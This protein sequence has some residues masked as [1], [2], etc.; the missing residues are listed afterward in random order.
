MGIRGAA[1][2]LGL[3]GL[4][5]SCHPDRNIETPPIHESG[6]TGSIAGAIFT[7]TPDGTVVNENVGYAQKIEVYLD[8][9]PGPNAPQKAA[10]LPD[11]AYYFQV[12]D[13]SG[14]VLLS[15]D[16]SMCRKVRVANG[17]I[18]ELLNANLSYTVGKK[19]IACHVQDSPDGVAGPSGRHDLNTDA[20]HGGN[21]AIVV[22]LMPFLDTPNN[23][24]VY[25]AWM[26][27]EAQYQDNGG[28]PDAIPQALT[29]KVKGFVPDPGF[30]GAAVPGSRSQVKTDNFKVKNPGKPCYSPLLTVKKFHDANFNGVWDAGEEAITGWEMTITDPTGTS[31]TAFTPVVDLMAL[32][33]GAW[34]VKEALPAGTLQTA[35]FLD[36]AAQPVNQTV[37]VSFVGE[38]TAE[39]HE[40]VFGNVATT[41]VTAC[42]FYDQNANGV[43]DGSDQ[44]IA[45]W[46]MQLSGGTLAAP[47]EQ[48][49]GSDGCTAFAS[50]L[51][52]TYTV[53]E[54]VPA[55]G[56]WIV[57]GSVAQT[58]TLTSTVSGGAVVGTAA[59]L[60]FT[61][62]C[63][64]SVGFGT[65]GYWHNKNGL[66][67]L[68]DADIAYVNGLL[69]YSAT[70]SYF[71]AGDEPFD[72]VFSD[73]TP[74]AAPTGDWAEE[75]AP[76]GT[77][78][79]EVSQF[80]V[81]TNQNANPREQLAQQ[82]LA[83]IFNARNRLGGVGTAFQLPDGT[84][85]VAGTLIQTAIDKWVGGSDAE[86]IAI[87]D[88][89]DAMN[90]SSAVAFIHPTACTPAY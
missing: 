32:P 47:I 71:D 50:L 44:A 87:K 38:C 28:D 84:W 59:A 16:P 45:G 10:G 49:T 5:C 81:D 7:T 58:V 42:K 73:G 21:G 65:K 78:R 29:G 19:T 51:P 34:T 36:G 30:G 69:P 70:S 48:L 3:A 33:V 39:K 35:A 15:E 22:Q 63:T 83:F 56:G 54:L 37:A 26:V 60:N 2:S 68:T 57:T 8:G 23:G 72:G 80:L 17:I 20:D 18:V 82:L 89:L 52:G 25:K 66:T 67:E 24:G 14:K 79:A 6:L 27:T 61:N 74:V 53:T 90:N 11:G 76:A 1:L 85:T 75:L 55:A 40:V 9:G 43:V 4:L 46:K 41:S 31:N 86:Q 62:A 64:G 13:P 12:T 77:P 88:I